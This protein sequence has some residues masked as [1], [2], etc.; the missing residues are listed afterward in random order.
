MA[1][2][3]IPGYIYDISEED[4]EELE[5]LLF[6]FGKARRRAYS[7]KQK[8]YTRSEIEKILHEEICLNGRYVKDAYHSVKDLPPHVTFG[9][10]NNQRLREKGKISKEEFHRRRNSIVI[11]RGEKSKS[12]NLN[13]RLDLERM[14][15]RINTG[16]KKWIY[17]KVYIP[18]KYL[19]RYG[20]LLDGSAPYTVLI[21][22]RD[23][24]YD[25]R[26]TVEIPTEVKEGERVMA[27]DINAGHIDF[28]V[29]EKEKL[30][31]V[32]VGIIEIHETQFVRKGKREYRIHSAVD[33]IGNIAKHYDADVFVGKLNTGKFK[34]DNKKANREVK[35]MPQYKF[36]KALK[37]LERKGIKVEEKSEKNTTKVGEKIS[38]LVGLDAHKCSAIAFAIKVIS[39]NLFRKFITLLSVVSSNEGDGSLRGRQRGGKRANRPCSGPER[40]WAAPQSGYPAIPGSWGL[41]FFDRLRAGLPCIRVKVC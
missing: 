18:K 24:G 2:V 21:K 34:S 8:G 3:T 25:V 1:K 40:L 13:M 15:L 20:H 12:G 23:D 11:S 27:L 31:V 32:S 22:R 33:K 19:D 29:L 37:K 36:R 39:Y 26:I 38:P 4:R 14:E 30:E 41:S 7:L 10:L 9:G 28:A 5:K 16:H 6:K 35:N 17:P